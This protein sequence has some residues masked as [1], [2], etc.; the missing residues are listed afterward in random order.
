MISCVEA[1]RTSI[2]QTDQYERAYYNTIE[3]KQ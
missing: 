3:G 1:S 2:E